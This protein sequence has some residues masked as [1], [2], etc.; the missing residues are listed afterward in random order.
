MNKNTVLEE[1]DAKISLVLEKYNALKNENNR[2]ETELATMKTAFEAKVQEISKL[3]EEDELKDLE[4]EDIA[5]KIS[6]AMGLL[7]TSN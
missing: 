2:L 4:L 6:Q 7:K 1:L 5:G 3:K